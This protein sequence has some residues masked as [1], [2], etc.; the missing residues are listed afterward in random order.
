M[1]ERVATTDY[2][3]A[4]VVADSLSYFR[5]QY[6]VDFPVQPQ[7]NGTRFGCACW[8]LDFGVCM[9]MGAYCPDLT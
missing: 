9:P 8:M 7:I 2:V 3:I 1:Q 6:R 5:R 4:A